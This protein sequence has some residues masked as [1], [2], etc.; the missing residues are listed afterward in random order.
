MKPELTFNERTDVPSVTGVTRT[1]V[2]AAVICDAA[3]AAVGQL[4]IWYCHESQCS[5]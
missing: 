3:D 2:V 5:R 4:I 1:I